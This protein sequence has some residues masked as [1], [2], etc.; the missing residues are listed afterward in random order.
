MG[1][2]FVGEIAFIF[3]ISKRKF[4]WWQFLVIKNWCHDKFS[5]VELARLLIKK[6]QLVLW[7]N[8][9]IKGIRKISWIPCWVLWP[10]VLD[11]NFHRF[12]CF[13]IPSYDP[14]IY[15]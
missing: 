2:R 7:K 4:Y 13:F 6:F 3:A 5:N 1:R 10:F 14:S 11:F 8:K 15:F 9:F 12:S